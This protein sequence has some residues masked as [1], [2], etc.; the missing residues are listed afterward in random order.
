MANLEATGDKIIFYQCIVP[1]CRK[2]KGKL[3]GHYIKKYRLEKKVQTGTMGCTDRCSNA[4]VLHLHPDDIWF[5]EK[6][7]GS[8]FKKYILNR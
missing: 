7:L 2:K 3:L 4:P 6:D 8:V 1:N 5:S